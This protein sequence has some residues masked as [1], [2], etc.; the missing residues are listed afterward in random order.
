MENL[1]YREKRN[2]LLADIKRFRHLADKT[3][4]DNTYDHQSCLLVEDL[5]KLDADQEKIHCVGEAPTG[6]GLLSGASPS[7]L[8]EVAR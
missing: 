3:P 6:S 7:P 5:K 2:K 8:L 1:L 4:C